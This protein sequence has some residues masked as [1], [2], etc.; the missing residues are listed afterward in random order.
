M[1][2]LRFIVL[3]IVLM[4]GVM[5]AQKKTETFSIGKTVYYKASVNNLHYLYTH[6]DE[7]AWRKL[8]VPLGYTELGITERAASL[9][10]IKGVYTG[11]YHVITF[12]S[13]FGVVAITWSDPSGKTSVT[14]D[15]E[16][17]L[18]PYPRQTTSVNTIYTVEKDKARYT[19]CL[20]KKRDG[21][22]LI[23]ETTIELGR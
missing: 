19:I 8:L 17:E 16:K 22:R 3:L 2:R 10:Y 9:H 7:E 5:L 13:D 23:E 21:A 12:D 18:S 6:L 4:P 20:R 15:I 1:S 14:R 11:H